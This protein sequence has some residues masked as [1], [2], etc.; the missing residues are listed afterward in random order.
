LARKPGDP[1]LEV[2]GPVATTNVTVPSKRG[3][4]A[5]RL[6]D[7]PVRRHDPNFVALTDG[8]TKLVQGHKEK[9]KQKAAMG[10]MACMNAIVQLSGGDRKVA[11]KLEIPDGVLDLI[12][13]NLRLLVVGAAMM[14]LAEEAEKFED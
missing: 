14:S 6:P 11:E 10:A 2:F 7:N 5:T 3:P 9:D 4:A 8:L 1:A 13:A 12:P